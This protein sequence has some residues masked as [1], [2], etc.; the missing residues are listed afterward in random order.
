MS[1]FITMDPAQ[2]TGLPPRKHY[3]Q[4][5]VCSHRTAALLDLC[6]SQL[7]ITA[8]GQPPGLSVH[9]AATEYADP[10]HILLHPGAGQEQ[11]VLE[12]PCSASPSGQ[13]H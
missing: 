4:L 11:Q 2:P 1:N 8:A 12:C 6:H 9:Y 3:R 10:K 5:P 13:L 7:G